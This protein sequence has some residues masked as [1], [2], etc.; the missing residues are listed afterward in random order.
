MNLQSPTSQP[1]KCTLPLLPL[2]NA[3]SSISSPLCLSL[4]FT[5]TSSKLP[6]PSLPLTSS[7]A[8]T[9]ALSIQQHLQASLS[10]LRFWNLISQTSSSISSLLLFP[11]HLSWTSSPLPTSI[12]ALCV[13]GSIIASKDVLSPL[14]SALLQNLP[15]LLLLHP[16]SPLEANP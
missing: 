10:A 14:R 6:S 12:T 13:A 11:V 5:S 4:S 1:S 8:R 16:T 2:P 3:L 9:L 7:S 15:H